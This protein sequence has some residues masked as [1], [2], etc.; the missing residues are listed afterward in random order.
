M[1]NIDIRVPS[2]I[3]WK[4]WELLNQIF[5]QTVKIGELCNELCLLARGGEVDVHVDRGLQTRLVKDDHCAGVSCGREDGYEGVQLTLPEHHGAPLGP[6][7][8]HGQLRMVQVLRVQVGVVSAGQW[9]HVPMLVVLKHLRFAQ[10][11]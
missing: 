1:I 2:Q 6:G 10:E 9:L 4:P 3:D 7:C 5:R 8:V 11:H